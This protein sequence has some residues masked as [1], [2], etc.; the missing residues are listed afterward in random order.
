M[1]SKAEGEL[2]DLQKLL[3][4]LDGDMD[5]FREL[6]SVFLEES[7]AMIGQIV[8]G[9]QNDDPACVER[10]AHTLKGISGNLEAKGAHNKAQILEHLARQGKIEELPP[11]LQCLREELAH[12]RDALRKAIEGLPG[13]ADR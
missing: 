10:V 1:I 2:F 11:A 13:T 8:E 12:L 3:E 5:V 7:A 9:L 4:N 6:V